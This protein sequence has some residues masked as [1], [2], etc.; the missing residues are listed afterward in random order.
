MANSLDSILAQA[1]ESVARRESGGTQKQ[2]QQQQQH[3][4]LLRQKDE[5]LARLRGLLAE[6]NQPFASSAHSSMTT[7]TGTF[8]MSI[9]RPRLGQLTQRGRRTRLGTTANR[10]SAFMP[11]DIEGIDD[12]FVATLRRKVKEKEEALKARQVAALNGE[13]HL[14]EVPMTVAC[15]SSNG[16]ACT[17]V[18]TQ[19]LPL[20]V[21]SEAC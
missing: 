15:V 19:L 11:S 2:Q 5:E 8:L 20:P 3:Q 7:T 4:E 21:T 10:Q 1:K 17:P 16:R 14:M 18:L 13:H 9:V 12:V 6:R